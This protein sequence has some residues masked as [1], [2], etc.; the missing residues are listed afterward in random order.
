MTPLVRRALSGL[1]LVALDWWLII[2]ALVVA[3][4]HQVWWLMVPAAA[5]GLVCGQ[6]FLGGFVAGWSLV[7]EGRRLGDLGD[8]DP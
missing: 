7:R 5:Y 4:E 3:V 1:V 6:A 8:L 2:A